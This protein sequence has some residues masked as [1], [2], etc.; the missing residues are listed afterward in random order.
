M[1]FVKCNKKRPKRNRVSL[2]VTLDPDVLDG[3]KKWMQREGENNISAAVEGF[4]ACGIR[5]DCEG[6]RFYDESLSEED[7]KTIVKVGVDKLIVN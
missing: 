5:D 6:C 3:L 7:E 4:V 1:N 2:S